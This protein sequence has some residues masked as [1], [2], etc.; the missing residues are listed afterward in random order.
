MYISNRIKLFFLFVLILGM[1]FPLSSA[2]CAPCVECTTANFQSVLIDPSVTITSAS[3]IPATETLPE[4]C[5]VRGTIWPEL[6]FAVKLPTAGWNNNLYVVGNGG[7]AGSIQEDDMIPGLEKGYAAAGGNG[8]HNSANGF[9]WSFAWPPGGPTVDAKME[10]F[11]YTCIHLVLVASKQLV[12][13]YYCNAPSYSYFHSCS[14]G[15]RQGLIEAQRYPEDFD[16]LLIGAPVW[17]TTKFAIRGAWEQQADHGEWAIQVEKLPLLAD[18]VFANCDGRDGLI[19]GLID[20]SRNCTFDPARDLP[21]CVAGADGPDC[22]TNKQIETLQKWYSGA[23]TS[24]GEKLT[25]GQPYGASVGWIPFT[26]IPPDFPL[27]APIHQLMVESLLKYYS[28]LVPPGP[29]YDWKTFDFD[30][31]PQKMTYKN[32]AIVSDLRALKQGGGKIIHYHG[33]ADG[34][35]VPYQSILYYENVLG[36]MGE[37]KTKEF[38]KLYMVPGMEHCGGGVGCGD[39]DWLT[40]ISDWVEKGVAPKDLIG[41]TDSGDRTR[42]ICPYP[43]VARYVGSGSIN[44][45]A[46][47]ACINIVPAT[48]SIEDQV[49]DLSKEGYFVAYLDFP[50]GYDVSGINITAALCEGASAEWTDVI[51]GN[52]GIA[53]F[54]IQDML[55]VPVGDAVPLTV[56]M[57]VNYNGSLVVLEGTAPTKTVK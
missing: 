12:K 29:E 31:D 14:G 42:P 48:V 23:S 52:K 41:A 30:T 6:D 9:D 44:D 18:A 8:G 35:I 26:V 2:L 16:G 55:N 40:A 19:D 22:F 5:D 47:F 24:A 1:F 37:A 3:I 54:S 13:A 15:G 17:D 38:Y 51:G 57:A 32:D 34:A 39:V 4:H 25:Y 27:P 36:F 43:Q 46:N 50:G 7:S 20:D 56:T 10:Q 33:W 49:I 21:L 28:F 53:L 11:D 45:A